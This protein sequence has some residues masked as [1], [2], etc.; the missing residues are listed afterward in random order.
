MKN[1]ATFYAKDNGNTSNW[2]TTANNGLWGTKK[3]IYDPCPAGYRVADQNAFKDNLTTLS[4]TSNANHATYAVNGVD[5]IL[6]LCGYIKYA[7]GAREKRASYADIWAAAVNGDKARAWRSEASTRTTLSM[8][9][10][11]G[12]PV[13][14]QKIQ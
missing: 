6:P 2:L 9:K 3:T 11:Y 8:A 4:S 12:Y 10:A 13:R 14:C 7:D 5:V 1:P